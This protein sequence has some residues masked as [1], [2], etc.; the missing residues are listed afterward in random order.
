MNSKLEGQVQRTSHQLNLSSQCL[1][2]ADK[3]HV[4]AA[5]EMNS[6]HWTTR[7]MRAVYSV[8]DT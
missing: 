7:V 3:N 8:D 4:L 1:K 2:E 6:S 5:V